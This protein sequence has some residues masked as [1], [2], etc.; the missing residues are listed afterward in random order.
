MKLFKKLCN[1]IAQAQATNN[2][3]NSFVFPYSDDQAQK[4]EEIWQNLQK[5]ILLED[6]G[7]LVRWGLDFYELDGIKE[8]RRERADRTEWLLGK[9]TILGGYEANL[10]IMRWKYRP[11]NEPMMQVTEKLGNDDEGL[12]RFNYL[13]Q[14]LTDL[15]GEPTHIDLKKFGEA[16]IGELSWEKGHIALTLTGIEKHML[17]YTFTIGVK[18]DLIH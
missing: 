17:R 9:R 18:T 11:E 16:D 4:R 6:K 10:E 3:K 15:L 1:L 13:R 5:G 8:Q 12:Q 7:I 2:R 14:Y